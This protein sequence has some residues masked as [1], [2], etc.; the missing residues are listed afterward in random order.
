[1][2]QKHPFFS[3]FYIFVVALTALLI[4]SC[5]RTPPTP[6]VSPDPVQSTLPPVVEPTITVTSGPA[7]ARVNGEGITLLDYQA[8]LARLDASLQET[9]M[10]L[11]ASEQ[12]QRVLDEL[13]DQMLL[14]QAARQGGFV[15]D[16][17][18]LNDRIT[19]LGGEAAANGA[20]ESALTDWQQKYG[21]TPESFRLALTLAAEAA[22][23]RD[24]IAN[25]V[26]EAVEQV[27][28][29]QILVLDAGLAD[30]VS[31]S[32]KSGADFATLAYQYEPLTGGDLGWFPRG[33]LTQP[34]VEDAAFALQPEQVSDVIETPYGYHIVQVLEHDAQHP[35]SGDARRFLQRKA[36][37][38][39]LL[40][41]RQ[42]AQIEILIEP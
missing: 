17:A 26:P 9:G 21:Y 18:A 1:M 22:W 41:Q 25:S 24:Q 36:V 8:E 28:A 12:S 19:R 3:S 2:R 6:T 7:A 35:L 34:A 23:Q 29:R 10:V 14:A 5:N 37:A 40:A 15:L 13:I 33:Y 30:Q 31:G 27:H 20:G 16:E 42:Q 4:A 11:T 38:D 32:L 39:W